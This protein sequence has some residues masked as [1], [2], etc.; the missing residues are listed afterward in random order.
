[1]WSIGNSGYK[2]GKFYAHAKKTAECQGDLSPV[3]SR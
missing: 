3:I 1:M 2:H